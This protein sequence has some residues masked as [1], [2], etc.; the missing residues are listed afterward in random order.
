[1]LTCCRQGKSHTHVQRMRARCCGGMANDELRFGV[2]PAGRSDDRQGLRGLTVGSC[3]PPH[4]QTN[5]LQASTIHIPIIRGTSHSCQWTD[6]CSWVQ[7]S[8]CRCRT[9][10]VHLCL[11]S[12]FA[13]CPPGQLQGAQRPPGPQA[14]GGPCSFGMCASMPPHGRHFRHRSA[15]ELLPT[16]R[17]CCC[18]EPVYVYAQVAGNAAAKRMHC[19]L[20][21]L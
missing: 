5:C 8:H 17:C 7:H 12:A 10:A 9:C 14:G 4:E 11:S 19:Q 2:R 16:E 6:G 20:C 21:H 3:S 13:R 18:H 1:M 15:S